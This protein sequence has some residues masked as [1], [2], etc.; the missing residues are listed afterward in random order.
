MMSPTSIAIN[1]INYNKQ[2]VDE[3]QILHLSGLNGLFRK[4]T[5]IIVN[6]FEKLYNKGLK[7]TL[8]IVIQ[9]NFK[10]R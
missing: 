10:S 6:I 1:E 2:I 8:N 3:I 9:G 7:F 5:D 4:R